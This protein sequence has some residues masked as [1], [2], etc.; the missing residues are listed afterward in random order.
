MYYYFHYLLLLL[1]SRN[2]KAANH[3]KI[4]FCFVQRMEEEDGVLLQPDD[5]DSNG[6]HTLLLILY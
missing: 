5:T 3:N 4:C 2:I 6:E 1:L